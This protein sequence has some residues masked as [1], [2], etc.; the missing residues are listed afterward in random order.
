VQDPYWDKDL[1]SAAIYSSQLHSATIRTS[2]RVRSSKFSVII[3][4]RLFTPSRWH[5]DLCSQAKGTFSTHRQLANIFTKP[6]DEK[7]FCELRS[8]L[9]VL[10]LS[11][12]GLKYCTHYI[13]WHTFSH[14][15][16]L[17]LLLNCSYLCMCYGSSCRNH[18]QTSQ[19]QVYWCTH[20]G[21]G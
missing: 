18:P 13:F 2:S 8:E 15:I 10:D 16:Y 1:Y 5:P 9:N 11:K 3:F 6:L 20:L 4:I 12:H 17:V 7:Q 19:I 21:G 14:D